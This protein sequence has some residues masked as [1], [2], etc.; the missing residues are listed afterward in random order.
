[1]R[2]INVAPVTNTDSRFLE[3]ELTQEKSYWVRQL[4]G[5]LTAAGI[6]L[7]FRRSA[8]FA[9]RDAHIDFCLTPEIC[10]KLR[11]LCGD[12]ESLV[13]AV[14]AAALKTCLHKYNDLEDIVIGTAIHEQHAGVAQLNKVLALRTRVDETTTVRRLLEDVRQ[15]VADAY[16]H[17]K[18]PFERILD[19]LSIEAPANRAP[20][21]SVV[22]VYESINN[23]ANVAHLLNDVTVVVSRRDDVLAGSIVYSTALY[24]RETLDIFA[25]HYT[26]IL[27][28]VLADADSRIADFDLLSSDEKHEALLKF[29]DTARAYPSDRTIDSLIEEQA[30]RAPDEVAVFAGARSL[31]YS[32]LDRRANQLARRLCSLGA[33]RGARV[34]LYLEH[35]PETIVAILATLKTGASYVPFDP[36]QPQ[37][38]VDFMLED[39]GVNVILTENA[40]SE[41][42]ATGRWHVIKLDNDW[43]LIAAGTEDPPVSRAH[44]DDEAYLIYTSGSTGNPKGVKVLHSSLVNYIWWAQSVYLRGD[45]LDFPLYSSLTFDLTVT[46]I[47]TPLITGN[48]VLIYAG[49]RRESIVQRILNDGEAGV[50]K[51]TPSHL[52]L[53]KD[54]DNRGSGVKR[55]IVGGEPLETK[56]AREV[57]ESFGGDVEIFNEYGPTEATVGCMIHRFDPA[58]DSRAFVPIGRPAANTRIYLLDSALRPAPANLVGELYIGG[59]GVAAG[60]HNRDDLTQEKFLADPFVPRGRMYRTGDLAR[61]LP[62]GDLDFLGRRDEQI[63]F[64]GHRVELNELRSAL[65]RHAEIRDSVVAVVSDQNG[66][67]TM[68]A[69]YCS[70]RELDL[71]ELRAFLAE[72]LIEEI[73]PNVFVHLKKLPLTLNGKVNRRALPT[74]QE[75]RARLKREYAPPRTAEEKLLANIWAQALCV[76]RVGIYENF[77]SLGGDSILSIRIIAKAR[78]AGMRLIPKQLF[79]Y[80]TVA[81]LAAVAGTITSAGA[82]QGLVTGPVPL[83]P[84]QR[85]FFEQEQPEPHHYNQS[86]VLD[87]RREVDP[88]LLNRALKTLLQ[89]HDALRLSFRREASGWAQ[90]NE[91]VSGPDVL[92]CVDLSDLPPAERLSALRRTAAETQSSL[93]LLDGSLLRAVLFKMGAGEPDRLLLVIHHLVVDGVS[94]RILIEDLQTACDESPLPDKTDSF[95]RWAE[96]LREHAQSQ[97]LKQELA[98]WESTSEGARLPRDREHGENTVGSAQTIT[99]SLDADETQALLH[100]AGV[101][102]Q[103]QI[104]DLLLTALVQVLAPWAGVTSLTVDLEGH[105]R[106]WIF[107]ELDVSRTVGWFTSI[108]PVTLALETGGSMRECL[109]SV[110]EQLRRVP[111]NGIGYGLL[112]YLNDDAESAARLARL[113][114]SEVTFNYLGQ[115]EELAA[116]S[117]TFVIRSESVGPNRSPRGR[118]THV[119]DVAASVIGGQLNLFWTYSQNLHERVTIERLAEEYLTAL[120]AI[121]SHCTSPDAGGYTPSDFPEAGLSQQELDLLLAEING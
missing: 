50:L 57:H 110:K 39:A 67:D 111:N 31:T 79:Q 83:T 7:D 107:E 105:G 37:A 81:E 117:A 36:G 101:A 118:R 113:S 95:K 49:D 78:Q 38:R 121:V 65:N 52:S 29:N 30:V 45:R 119:L 19:A 18:Y 88:E 8:T 76:D 90:V 97:E 99:V 77:F 25:K 34:G 69:Y 115:F 114:K 87:L 58:A 32:E 62:N 33:N 40:F 92:K 84:V 72:K 60:Y 53:I 27:A 41:R 64:H 86:V 54:R 4:S 13:F 71:A 68:I 14:L 24:H 116:G 46:S 43:D 63:K 102:Y 6:P 2:E 73:I 106:E 5:E 9:K 74:L 44:P 47:F 94:W 82:E 80:Q 17:Q 103:T 1:M 85:W 59:D 91:G 56:L 20:F 12:N 100:N 51:L 26:R 98:F 70:R 120:R 112:R 96:R 48:R 66:H 89:H 61:R 28:A 3:V 21:F 35:S 10:G 55:L 93:D 16:T 15:T 108:Y 42:F 104:N 75:A 11:Q 23:L 109:T 22:L